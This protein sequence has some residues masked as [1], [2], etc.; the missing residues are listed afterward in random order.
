MNKF[1]SKIASVIAALSIIAPAGLFI[2]PATALAATT[3]TLATVANGTYTAWLGNEADVDEPESTNCAAGSVIVGAV[4][5]TRESYTL[6]LSSI[7]NGS[8]ITSVDV[9]VRDRGAFF[10]GGTYK[11]FT[12]LD[13]A[14]A[15]AISNLSATGGLAADCSSPKTQTIDVAD[16]VKSGATTLEIGVLKV[17]NLPLVHVGAMTAV[18]TY[19]APTV[20]V[21]IAKFINGVQATTSNVQSAAFPMYAIYPGG[22]GD[23]TLSATG[24]NNPDAYKATTS[25]MPYGSNYSTYENA[26]ASC[27]AAY[28][29][30]L[31]GYTTDETLEAAMLGTPTEAVPAFVG[32][33]SDKFVI[34]WN[35]TCPPAPVNVSPANGS[36]LTTAAWDKADWTDV[37]D[38][39][40]P[41]TYI[42]ESSLSSGTNPDGSFTSPVYVSGP[43]AVSEIP[44]TGTPEGTY[45]WHAKGVDNAGNPGPWSTPFSAT[46]SNS[47]PVCPEGLS[48]IPPFCLPIILPI[49]PFGGVFPACSPFPFT[50]PEGG[51]WPVC[52]PFPETNASLTI[53]KH[54][55][56]GE[57]SFDFNV[58]TEEGGTLVGSANITASEGTNGESAP[59]SLLPGEYDVVELNEVD[60]TLTN[61]TCDYGDG[62]AGYSIAGGEEIAVE[63][64][65]D[66]TCTFTNTPVGEICTDDSVTLVS[67]GTTQVDGGN[68]LLLLEGEPVNGNRQHPAWTT[69][70]AG[71]SWIWDLDGVNTPTENE[72][73]VFTKQ[74]EIN[75][76]V[77]AAVLDIATDNSYVVRLNGTIVAED[78]SL[79]NYSSA[80]QYNIA[81]E[82]L[83]QGLNTL[84]IT[85]TNGAWPEGENPAGL[86]FKLT[87]TAGDCAAE[88]GGGG[89]S[90]TPGS[91]P[92]YIQ[93]VKKSL[94]AVGT[95]DFSAS[96]PGVDEDDAEFS[97]T[98]PSEDTNEDYSF[99]VYPSGFNTNYTITEDVPAGWTLTSVECSSDTDSV[100]PIENGVVIAVDPDDTPTCTFTNTATGGSLTIIKQVINDDGEQ[101]NAGDF[102]IDVINNDAPSTTV[103]GSEEGTTVALDAGTYR[104]S[105]QSN[106]NYEASYSAE[107]EGTIAIG[108]SKTCTITNNDVTEDSGNSSGSS[109]NGGGNGGSV[110][111][112]STDTTTTTNNNEGQVLG[113]SCP[114]PSFEDLIMIKGD[115]V[116]ADSDTIKTLQEWLNSHENAG[117]TV[118]GVYDA[119]TK[120]AIMLFQEKY[121]ETLTQWGLSK[122]T[123]NVWLTTAN[124]LRRIAG[125]GGVHIPSTSLFTF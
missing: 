14:N 88:E 102:S 19:T 121:S 101:G 6:D 3:T 125:C 32:L 85:V 44:T 98:T 94:G 84:E 57:G 96:G 72:T 111:G 78:A 66:V 50:C 23:Y 55:T 56:S 68:S 75:G 90:G 91:V 117:L 5:N 40:S 24:F 58:T 43:L 92:A 28:P 81:T 105:E 59:I 20:K 114:L 63:A 60:W 67:D 86:L 49:C 99:N 113:A 11:T 108:E 73:E 34:V 89:G 95:F 35:K 21:T 8:E 104:V 61:V 71:A 115:G 37:T 2:A 122:A 16:T 48:G 97:I 13:G 38:W 7:P 120:F 54:V 26:P 65:D 27:T 30:K 80:D 25:N 29:Y 31:V 119:P 93:I 9:I 74:F 46:V 116:D 83:D 10:A 109:A 22:A 112:A 39:S 47:S 82:D 1:V 107:C 41:M 70:I 118:T 124:T 53:V 18:V 15:D 45:Y 103:T 33:T 36:T 42:Y 12:R 79:D 106:N 4:N 69:S 51:I 17:G 110:L 123:G 87:V 64:G 52:T 77:S 76:P 100:T 62:G